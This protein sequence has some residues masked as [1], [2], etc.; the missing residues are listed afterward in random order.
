MGPRASLRVLGKKKKKPL[1]PIGKT[2][3][4]PSLFSRV[5]STDYA[6]MAAEL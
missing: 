6:N 1:V 2:P 4:S 3:A 5:L